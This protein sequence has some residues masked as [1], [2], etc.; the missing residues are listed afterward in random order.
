MGGTRLALVVAVL[1][2]AVG[3]CPAA[4]VPTSRPAKPVVKDGLSIAAC[5][6]KDE[7]AR[8]ETIEIKVTF[9]N[10]SE[11]PI[12]LGVSKMLRWLPT[13]GMFFAVKDV[14]TGKVRTLQAGVNPMIRMPV[15]MENKTI[16]T[17]GSVVVP[18]AIDRW[19]WEAAPAAGPRLRARQGR[20]YLGADLLAPGAYEIT[21]SCSFGKGFGQGLTFWTGEIAAKAFGIRVTDKPAAGGPPAGGAGG[22]WIKLFADERWYRSQPGAERTFMGTLQA[23]PDAGGASTLMRTAYYKLGKW[24]LYT[25]ARK[26]PELDKLVGKGVQIRGKE[27]KMNLEGRALQEIWPGAVRPGGVQISPPVKPSVS[28]PLRDLIRTR[29]EAG[30]Q[31]Q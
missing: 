24:R 20:K 16:P 7:F 15:R 8:G 26:H 4:P 21:V 23:A 6:V 2:I 31:Q 14:Q 25:G 19:S 17:G 10:V 22:Q 27:V 30:G 11:K 9:G 29:T 3:V 13:G 28:P 18:A 12:V 5:P 1:A